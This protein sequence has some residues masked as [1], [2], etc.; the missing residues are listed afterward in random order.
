MSWYYSEKKILLIEKLILT[1][2]KETNF[3]KPGPLPRE[4]YLGKGVFFYQVKEI[5]QGLSLATWI[6][7]KVKNNI[8]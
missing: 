7:S 6:F 2:N 4:I 8:L 5:W 3:N 1:W